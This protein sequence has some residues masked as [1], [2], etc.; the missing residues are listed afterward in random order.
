[1]S[2][3][4]KKTEGDYEVGYGKP[5]KEHQFKRKDHAESRDKPG[6]ARKRTKEEPKKVDLVKLLSAS[7]PVKT[8]GKTRKMDP[9]E[10]MLRKQAK[11]AVSGSLPGI[12]AI[13]AAAIEYDLLHVP[14]SER[15]GGV[16]IFSLNTE[17]DVAFWRDYFG[18]Q[19]PALKSSEGGDN[20]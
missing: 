1:M 14:P 12:K 5:P 10:I 7:I 19:A 3:N 11:Q 15:S 18:P 16:M 8:N 4:G 6:R 13:L 17:D 20:D 2:K 9:L